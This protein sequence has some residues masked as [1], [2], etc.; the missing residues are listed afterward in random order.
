[1]VQAGAVMD[2][3]DGRLRTASRPRKTVILLESYVEFGVFS[4]VW[5]VSFWFCDIGAFGSVGTP[6]RRA[7]T[8]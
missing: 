4:G 8:H 2:I 5:P 7:E 3:T 1:V 6:V